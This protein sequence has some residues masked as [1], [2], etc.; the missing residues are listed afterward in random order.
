MKV[1]EAVGKGFNLASKS[2][3]V[4][5]VLFVFNVAWN[6]MSIPFLGT[7]QT[8]AQQRM[9]PQLI[10]LSLVFI[11]I[12][13]FLQGGLF[14]V[15]KDAVVSDGAPVLN[16]FVK[17]SRKFFIRFLG[18][19]VVII[20]AVALSALVIGTIFSLSVVVKNIILNI[21]LVSL[22]IILTLIALYYLFLFFLSPYVLV[23]D[24]IGVFKALKNSLQ[25]IKKHFLKMV[26]LTTIL[27]LIGFGIGFIV[28]ILTG[29]LSFALKGTTF[30]IAIGIITGAVNAY[31]TV[32]ISAAFIVYY[33]GLGAGQKKETAEE[34]SASA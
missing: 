2:L 3:R 30:Q 12:N 19:G 18:L 29:G 11:L 34:T 15:L 23:V 32:I 4:M 16:N 21:V 26:G 27:V 8:P 17:Y 33:Y 31:T 5:A 24:D 14:G 1:I 28:G 6:L 22:G 9:N 20:L 10:G 7:T 13:I 25:F